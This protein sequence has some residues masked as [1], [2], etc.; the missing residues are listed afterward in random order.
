MSRCPRQVKVCTS[1]R[2]ETLTIALAEDV[3]T[4]RFGRN[5]ALH[6]WLVIMMLVQ[7]VA[8]CA[9]AISS[10]GTHQ[11]LPPA[12]EPVVVPIAIKSS[13]VATGQVNTSFAFVLT[14]TGGIAPYTWSVSAGSLP[15]ELGLNASTGQ[16]GGTPTQGGTFPM[17]IA[18]KDSSSPVRL[19]SQDFSINV[20]SITATP[21][22]ISAPVL[23]PPAAQG[24][25]YSSQN[26]TV[27]GGAV[28]NISGG[29]P[30][31]T[32]SV[33]SGSIPPGM[34]LSETT[35]QVMPA[36][37]CILSGPPAIAG[38]FTFTVQVTDA[39]SNTAS[40]SVAFQAQ[41]SN[42]PIISNINTISS[43]SSSERITWT[44]NVP[45]DSAVFYGLTTGFG[46]ITS[47]TDTGGVTSHDVTIVGVFP[48][49]A[50]SFGIESRAVAG[51]VVQDYNAAYYT[52]GSFIV[53]NPPST[54]T[55]D[56]YF[57][58]VGPHNV[59]QGYPMYVAIYAGSLAGTASQRSWKVHVTGIPPNSQVHWPDQ[60]DNGLAQGTVST[61]T[62][63]NDTITWDK[64]TQ[65]QFEIITNL[66]GT[67]PIGSYTLTVIATPNVGLAHSFTWRMVVGSST[68]TS[69][70]PPSQPPVPLLST[71]NSNMTS[72][73]TKW[74][75][76]SCTAG[77]DQCIDFYD[78]EWVY[79]QIAQYTGNVSTWSAA[80][81]NSRTLYLTYLSQNNGRLPGYWNF[82]H[83]LYNDCKSGSAAAAASCT[84]LHQLA[85]NIA[86]TNMWAS[87]LPYADAT[88]IREACYELSARRLDY[89]AGGGS[90]LTQIKQML[91]YCV[92]DADQVVNGTT[93][94]EQPFM[95]G[96][97][98]EALIECYEDVN[99]GNNADPRIPLAIQQ[100]ADHIWQKAWLPWA[101]VNGA[102]V[103]NMFQWQ[104]GLNGN[105]RTNGGPFSAQLEN[106]NLLIAPMYAWLYLKTGLSQYQLEGD[107][108]WCS[109]VSDPAPNGI[110]WSGKNFSQQYRWSVNYV[111]WR[112]AP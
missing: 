99:C 81:G 57:S 35:P 84:A 22:S 47:I 66:G 49:Q 9:G 80:A 90:T 56:Y 52:S 60:Q 31:Y 13:S 26:G 69:S 111:N 108:I 3:R 102:F 93:S 1:G 20:T 78:G 89:D 19:A 25:S 68:F 33:L 27:N 71:Y 83:G 79:Q 32:C 65:T 23:I 7:L 88:N 110:G 85:S 58:G 28:L 37:M 42:P 87:A 15:I 73:G 72:Y 92:G 107:T 70:N 103:Y 29:T 64:P 104:I 53:A 94:F 105:G 98:A 51:G 55:F 61:T 8:G 59:T 11:N 82:P 36:G 112:S 86:G 43:S 46:Q 12:A 75:S 76:Q 10:S 18:V 21:L 95:D 17:T 100:I 91:A 67:T 4:Q 44:T 5:A 6:L 30:P 97:A 34:T 16:I 38:D 2:R 96:L 101:G 63:T 41:S 24:T 40:Q 109:G 45:T 106:L 48:G 77:S 14:A 39:A 74:S 50:Y 54:G 62:A